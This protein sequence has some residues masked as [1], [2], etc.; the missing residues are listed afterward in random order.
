M[1]DHPILQFVFSL[2]N[3]F[4]GIG[5]LVLGLY[6]IPK[7]PV[8]KGATRVAAMTFAVTSCLAHWALAVRVLTRDPG[9]AT[10][11]AASWPGLIIHLILTCSLWF[12][13]GGAYLRVNGWNVKDKT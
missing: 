11:M 10:Q 5:F 7:N 6:V 1:S 13:L 3:V 2:L 8:T 9:S 4:A 12:F